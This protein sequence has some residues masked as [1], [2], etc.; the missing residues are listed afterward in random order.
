LTRGRTDEQAN[1]LSRQTS[2]FAT[3]AYCYSHGLFDSGSSLTALAPEACL[4]SG[5]ADELRAR[6]PHATEAEIAALAH[7]YAEENRRLKKHL[8]K[9]GDMQGWFQ[10]MVVQARKEVTERELEDEADGGGDGD[11]DME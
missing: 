9:G 11:V 1:D 4:W 10:G 2:V 3:L 5:D 8:D 7:D 6:F